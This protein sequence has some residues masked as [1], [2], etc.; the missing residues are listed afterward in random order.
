MCICIYFT[1][2]QKCL[3]IM[4]GSNTCIQHLLSWKTPCFR[5]EIIVTGEYFKHAVKIASQKV[6]TT[7]LRHSWEVIYFLKNPE[8]LSALTMILI[9]SIKWFVYAWT[10]NLNNQ[11]LTDFKAIMHS[12]NIWYKSTKNKLA[13]SPGENGGG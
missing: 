13:E 11:G 10:N 5:E 7:K 12:Y 4:Q 3:T 1:V 2:H 9:H 6:L 8:N